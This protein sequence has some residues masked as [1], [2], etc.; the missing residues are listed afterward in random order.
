QFGMDFFLLVTTNLVHNDRQD[1]L[2]MLF[3]EVLD[4]HPGCGIGVFSLVVGFVTV[5][6]MGVVLAIALI[7]LRVIPSVGF[8]G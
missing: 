8:H 6:T 4:I 3:T 1:I 5:V 2:V 7:F